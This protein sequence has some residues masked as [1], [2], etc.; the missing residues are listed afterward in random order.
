MRKMALW[1]SAKALPKIF[2]NTI[3]KSGGVFIESALCEIAGCK[4]L[5]LGTGYFPNDTLLIDAARQFAQ[6]AYSAQQHAD[7]RPNNLAI[8]EKFV[9]RWVVHFRDPRSVT[10]S[11]TC[12][13]DEI[14]RRGASNLLDHTAPIPDDDYLS[15]DFSDRLGSQATHFLAQG[16]EPT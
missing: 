15:L 3:P 9:S 2:V 6:G 7:C 13:L 5:I 16:I 14:V 12:H 10:L 1:K 11:W 4:H 8:L